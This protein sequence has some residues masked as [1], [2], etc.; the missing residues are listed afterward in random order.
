MF[1]QKHCWVVREGPPQEAYIRD[2]EPV[3]EAGPGVEIVEEPPVPT[4]AL[5]QDQGEDIR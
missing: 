1:R 4:R 2:D 5:T 3:Q